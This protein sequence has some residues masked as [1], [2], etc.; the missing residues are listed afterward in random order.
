VSATDLPSAAGAKIP[1]N[2][3]SALRR[4]FRAAPL[5]AIL[6]TSL[7]YPLPSSE[8][9]AALLR[10]GVRVIQYRHKKKFSRANFDQC[11]A[12]A[13]Q[14]HAAG[15]VFLVNDRADVAALCG[16]DGVH[17]GQ[18]DLPPGK[19]RAFLGPGKLIGYSTHRL[20]QAR[21]A[22][23]LPVDYIAIGPVFPTRTKE[24][25]DPV[26]GLS[27]VSEARRATA[28]PLVAI[29]GI[30]L[31][32]AA[33]VIVAGADAVAVASDLA[34][35]PDIAARAQQFLARAPRPRA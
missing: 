19:A 34:Q 31:E 7:K 3:G 26:V 10:G 8:V 21:L 18:F 14:V 29:G 27:V 32:N 6:D 16:A 15:G 1:A 4:L 25:A 9:V 17:L 30:T 20:E 24:N 22:D 35:M 13:E 5:Y 23:R 28:K 12:L 33:S 11:R 2:G